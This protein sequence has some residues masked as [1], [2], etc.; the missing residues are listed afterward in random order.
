MKKTI[1]AAFGS[2]A[3]LA[4][5]LPA[6]AVN[7]LRVMILD[8]ESGGPYHDWQHTTPVLKKELED[9]GLFMVDV[10]TAPQSGG[11]FSNFHPDFSR[12]Q[13]VVLNYDGQ[14][15]P[16]ELKASF[17][18]YIKDGGGLVIVH[19]ADNA[20][21]DWQDF[22]RMIGLGG[23]R[24]RNENSGPLWYMK[25]GKLVSDNSPGSAGS[26]GARLPFQVTTQ[27]PEHP[28][29]KGLPKVWTHA[30][31][32]LYATLRGPGENMTVLAT[33][34]SDP[35]NRGTGR[36]EPALMVLQYGKG[37]IFHTTMGHD[38]P[39]LSCVG[40]ITTFRRGTEWAATGKV[41]QEIPATFPTAETV[42]YRVDIAA[43]DPKYKDGAGGPPRPGTMPSGR[44]RGPA[45]LVPPVVQPG[46]TVPAVAQ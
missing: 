24:R 43:M 45:A 39:A 20:F 42:S 37:R 18:N 3:L 10:V 21:P 13:A 38:V 7:P 11:D 9:A 14:D 41:T 40:F 35:E 4:L 23:W 33:A 30:A 27:Q 1:C 19:A 12:Y 22:N 31:D 17:E 16:A 2:L 26:H 36:D 6:R 8:G 46:S 32:E 15:W 34:H 28:I 5:V 44:G 25:N 29:M